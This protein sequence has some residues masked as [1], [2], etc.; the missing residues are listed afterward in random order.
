VFSGSDL[1]NTRNSGIAVGGSLLYLANDGGSQIYTAPKNFATPPALFATLATRLE[2]MECDNVTFS[3]QNKTVMWVIDAYDRHVNAFVIPNGSCS[4]GGGAIVAKSGGCAVTSTAGAA[5]GTQPLITFTGPEDLTYAATIN[6]GDGSTSPGTVTSKGAGNFAVSGG[7][8]Y[9][10]NGS[11]TITVKVSDAKNP[12]NNSSANC[13]AT[14]DPAVTTEGVSAATTPTTVAAASAG[15]LPATGSS[16]APL[17]GIALGIMA[18]G[19]AAIGLAW[20]RRSTLP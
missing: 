12:S 20:R 7:H 17:T 5:T 18:I 2:D 14:I 8:T 11:Y 1:G 16:S 10:A 15:E 4:F 9:T 19:L 13:A 6:W 3:A